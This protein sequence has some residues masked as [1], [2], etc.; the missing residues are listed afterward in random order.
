MNACISSGFFV[1]LMAKCLEVLGDVQAKKNHYMLSMLHATKD[2][3][4]FLFF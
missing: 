4:I 2:Q 1:A 3:N